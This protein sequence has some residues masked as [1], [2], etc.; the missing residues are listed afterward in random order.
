MALCIISSSTDTAIESV[1]QISF[2][3]KMIQGTKEMQNFQQS[4]ESFSVFIPME[5]GRMSDILLCRHFQ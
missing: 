1:N 2:S 5:E 3:E 4:C